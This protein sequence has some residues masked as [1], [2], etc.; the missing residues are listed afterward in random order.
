MHFVLLI[1]LNDDN[2]DNYN[3]DVDA[4]LNTKKEQIQLLALNEHIGNK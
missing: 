4:F 2:N 1:V 3:D